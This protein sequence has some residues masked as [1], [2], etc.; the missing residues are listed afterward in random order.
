MVLEQAYMY[1]AHTHVVIHSFDPNALMVTT[2]LRPNG[3]SLSA[4]ETSAQAFWPC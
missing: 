4:M 3:R 2:L 1:L